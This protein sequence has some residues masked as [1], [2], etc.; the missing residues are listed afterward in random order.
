MFTVW[1][2][3]CSFII[4]FYWSLFCTKIIY[5]SF[6]LLLKFK[7]YTDHKSYLCILI[8]F[9]CI[10]YYVVFIK[11]KLQNMA[12]PTF[13]PLSVCMY[14]HVIFPD[15]KYN[16][17]TIICCM[18]LVWLPSVYITSA[19]FVHI[20]ICSRIHYFYFLIIFCLKS[21]AIVF[22]LLLIN[23]YLVSIWDSGE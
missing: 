22:V 20:V 3:P 2:I 18:H 12:K 16:R 7:L 23:I 15:F 17:N 9:I 21:N 10:Y 1:I 6:Y 13:C 14:N 4:Y 8:H 19:R 11:M 5:W